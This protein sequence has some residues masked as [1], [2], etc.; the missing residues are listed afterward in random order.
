MNQRTVILAAAMAACSVAAATLGP[1]PSANATCASFSGIN[2][3]SG[4]TSTLG[5]LAIALGPNA[6]A[7]A[8][9]FLSTAVG[10]GNSVIASAHGAFSLGIAGGTSSEAIAGNSQGTDLGN[11]A[12]ALGD[13]AVA[14][15]FSSTGNGFGNIATN[16][17][18][19]NEVTAIGDLNVAST[20][21][22]DTVVAEGIANYASDVGGTGNTVEAVG[23][24]GL[25]SPGFSTAF[26][27]FS[28]G[29]VVLADP[30]PLA[31][32][33]SI[34]Q[35]GATVAKEGPGF[36]INGVKVGGAAAPSAAAVHPKVATK[37]KPS[38]SAGP[39]KHASK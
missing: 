13:H 18:N 8:A 32:A 31:V 33:G 2:L 23:G 6:T 5:G 9:G 29:T 35:T 38:A 3:G 25:K 36:N 30:G 7:I 17:G 27:F 11:I 37:G 28:N 15:A 4:C 12:I 19:H 24:P 34:L 22:K 26:A 16:V 1:A 39:P 10:I 14:A 21:G 20:L